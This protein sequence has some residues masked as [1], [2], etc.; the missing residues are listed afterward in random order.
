MQ[1]FHPAV[2]ILLVIP[3]I[4]YNEFNIIVY[5]VVANII[6]ICSCVITFCQ[7]TARRIIFHKI[8]F[9]KKGFVINFNYINRLI[10]IININTNPYIYNTLI[11]V[12]INANDFVSIFVK[13]AIT[14]RYRYFIILK[15]SPIF[16]Y[17]HII[18]YT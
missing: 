11:I 10:F 17:T 7:F 14:N 5:I 16:T 13:N 12:R 8:V 2:F 3:I 18:T 15:Y 1:N 6:S 9:S 4:R